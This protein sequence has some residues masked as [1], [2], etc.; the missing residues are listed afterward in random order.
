MVE[1]EL[2]QY[3]IEQIKQNDGKNDRPLWVII[4]N[5]IY[6]VT[7]FNH[8]GGSE[9]LK[10]DHGEDRGEEF[11]SIHSKTAKNDKEKY[12]IGILKK[13]EEGKENKVNKNDEKDNKKQ[14]KGGNMRMPLLMML[15]AYIFIFKLNLIGLF[16]RPSEIYKK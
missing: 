1:K 11:D 10:D 13:E 9:A 3:T 4:H 14:Q 15:F 2:K 7:S 8:P 5:K 16:T 12:F 6:D